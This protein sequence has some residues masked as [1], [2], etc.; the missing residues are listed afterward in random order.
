ML[1][2]V[3]V[4]SNGENVVSSSELDGSAKLGP[5]ATLVRQKSASGL[6]VGRLPL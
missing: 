2:P 5:S 3:F 4:V 6:C 1:V